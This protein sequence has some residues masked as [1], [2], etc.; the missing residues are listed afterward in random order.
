[1]K[2]K[3]LRV[4][5]W[6]VGIVAIAALLMA[7][8]THGTFAQGKP[9][10]IGFIHA[11]TGDW[12]TT[13]LYIKNGIYMARDEWNAKGGINGNPITLIEEDDTSRTAGAVT[14]YNKVIT[15]NICSMFGQTYSTQV[16]AEAPF[17]IKT[18]VPYV[19]SAT[20]PKI[21]HMGN[22]WMF[23]LRTNDEVVAQILAHYVVEKMGIKKVAITYGNEEY[24]R[25]GAK[26][27]EDTLKSIGVTPVSI[28]THTPNDKDFTAQMLNMKKAGAQCIVSYSFLQEHGLMIKQKHELGMDDI[29]Y[30]GSPTMT[31]PI[32]MKLAGEAANYN[33]YG[34]ADWVRTDPRAQVQEWV[35][36]YE[37]KYKIEANNYTVVYYDGANMLFSSIAKAGTDPEAIR[38]QMH[39]IKGHKG[40]GYTYSF[41][42]DGDGPHATT[43]VKVEK[44]EFKIMETA[45]EKG[46]GPDGPIK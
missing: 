18:G 6:L 26:I 20:N 1:M 46:Y 13:S 28:T 23:R 2:R 9:I 44:G 17:I 11:M 42:E 33:V 43:I 45:F 22:K 21:T 4:G 36:K 38:K 10:R 25:T 39:Q 15:Q 31:T 27:V 16:L 34:V 8:Q 19:F 12:S 5:L 41:D 7:L 24:G 40:M 37:A 29:F 14:A 32:T 30:F 35:K 3:Q